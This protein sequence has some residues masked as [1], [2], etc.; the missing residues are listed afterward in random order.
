[1]TAPGARQHASRAVAERGQAVGVPGTVWTLCVLHL[2]LLVGYSI[3]VPTYRAPDEP[4]HVDLVLAVSRGQAWPWP[5]PTARADSRQV[6]GSLAPAGYADTSSPRERAV[7]PLRA[8]DAVPW[9]ARPSFG[10]LG[11]D[12]PSSSRNQMTQHPPL[13][14]LLGGAAVAVSGAQDWPFDRLVGAL[15]LGSV[16]LVTALPLLAYVAA[17]RLRAGQA[18]A[19]TAAVVPLAL[20]Q[21][22]HLGSTVSNDAL[23]VALLG[24]LTVLAAGVLT[25]DKRA[26][27]AVLM[28]L[29]AGLAL[30]TKG[31]ALL[32]PAWI[33]L[34]YAWVA[35]RD[36]RAL[37]AGVLAVATAL[38]SGG[39]WWLRN[40]VRYGTLQ[41]DG[42][43][44]P[45]AVGEVGA[46]LGAYL[47]VLAGAFPQRFWGS[48]G[49]LQV[50]LP[51]LAVWLATA[52]VAAGVVAALATR[53]RGAARGDLALLLFPLGATLGIVLAGSWSYYR[54]SGAVAGIQGRYLLTG[55]VG[56]AV[57]VAAGLTSLTPVRWHAWLPP[58]LLA[59]GALLQTVAI[60]TLV[61]GFW[62]EPASASAAA[63]LT[64]VLAWSPW[65]PVA[66]AATCSAV[67][68]V[69]LL[70]LG[71]RLTRRT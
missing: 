1:M 3:L 19:L 40:L 37:P 36:R 22:T 26:R 5:D 13:Y 11:P 31:F 32:T 41:P 8:A 34:V 21:L 24:L 12:V 20:P 68:V 58:T 33:A 65:P 18:A 9:G 14:Y 29:V 60:V 55:I 27:T 30:L 7:G 10:D 56:L 43:V 57:V 6:L 44:R 48:F 59:A 35:R 63:A 51:W 66:V 70:A 2:L 25:G 15:R 49:W 54:A 47:R 53:R 23:L 28:G 39:W 61:R 46:D 16:L 4:H 17:R 67:A 62:M 69:A 42:L 52:V 50:N 38:A 64:A 71:R 45:A